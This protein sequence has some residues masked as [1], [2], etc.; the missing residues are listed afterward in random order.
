MQNFNFHIPLCFVSLPKNIFTICVFRCGS[1]SSADLATIAQYVLKNPHSFQFHQYHLSHCWT[2]QGLHCAYEKLSALFHI[3]S[4]LFFAEW[5][6]K[7]REKNKQEQKQSR[8]KSFSVNINT[9][10][11]WVVSTLLE[12]V[13]IS[14]S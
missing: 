3:N 6:S 7:F 11:W 9:D 2:P 1:F 14:L 5:S 12:R 8:R 10:I 4:K 13:D